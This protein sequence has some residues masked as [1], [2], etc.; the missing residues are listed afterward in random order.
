V[1]D[2][3][4]A[5][6]DARWATLA[7]WVATRGARW[8]TLA[9]WLATRDARWATLAAWVATRGARGATFDFHSSVFDVPLATPSRPP[10]GLN[11][12]GGRA[13]GGNDGRNHFRIATGSAAEAC[14][15]PDLI[16][17]AE[18]AAQQPRLRRVGAMLRGLTR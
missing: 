10:P 15:C 17:T 11:L 12:A 2:A 18:A 4:L 16:G 9:A 7:A 3:R 5:T 1:G 13:R 14:A 8:A 6:R